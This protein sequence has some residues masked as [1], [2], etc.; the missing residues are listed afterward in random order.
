MNLGDKVALVTGAGRGIG[1]AIAR[2]FAA[3]GVRVALCDVSAPLLDDA[4]LQIEALGG[5]ALAFPMDVTSKEQID[6][7]VAEVIARWGSL[8]ILVNNAGIY[9]V[10][11]VEEISEAQW[12]RVLAVNLKG[13]FLCCQAVIPAMKARCSGRIVNVASSAGKTGGTLAGAH[14][15]ASKAGLINLTKQLARELGPLGITVNA[16]APGRID[17][18]MIHTVSDAENDAFVQRTPLGRLGMPEDVA[19]AVV[20]LASE[21]ASFI[22][23]EILDVNGGLLID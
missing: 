7:V 15:S 17:T 5:Q 2:A 10:L 22:T 19:D 23:G 18:P 20:F 11:P 14:Y 12:D 13:A 8:D 21:R 9:E 16:V 3:E 4:L 1:L 6:R